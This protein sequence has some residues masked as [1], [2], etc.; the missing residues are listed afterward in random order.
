M[1]RNLKK[2][3]TRTHETIKAVKKEE[4]NWWG[5]NVDCRTENICVSI[6]R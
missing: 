4:K 1:I 3:L 6:V 5:G 2:G